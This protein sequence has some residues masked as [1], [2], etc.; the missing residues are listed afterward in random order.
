VLVSN[1][2]RSSIDD[3]DTTGD[4]IYRVVME[5]RD[6]FVYLEGN[7]T[8]N[9]EVMMSLMFEPE[10]PFFGEIFVGF[11]ELT[12]NPGWRY[13]DP[14]VET[15]G[16][17]LVEI[18]GDEAVVRMADQRG[19]QVIANA[20]GTTVKTYEGWERKVTTLTFRR[21]S[22]G[23]WRYADLE[24]S[25]PITDNELAHMIPVEWTGRDL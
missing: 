7:P 19:P 12:E 13:V 3:F 18:S 15:L 1:V 14:G 20:E 9:A 25:V 4:D 5:L 6:L 8:G 16:V 22:D 21:G 17:E 23:R 2:N 10:Y 11:L 24:P